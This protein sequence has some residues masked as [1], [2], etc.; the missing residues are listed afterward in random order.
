MHTHMHKHVRTNIHLHTVKNGPRISKIKPKW[1]STFDPTT[2]A[3]VHVWVSEWVGEWVSEWV[4]KWLY[5]C[6]RENNRVAFKPSRQILTGSA[7]TCCWSCSSMLG[8]QPR[9]CSVERTHT[10]TR[11]TPIYTRQQKT[12]QHTRTNTQTHARTHTHAHTHDSKRPH[13]PRPSALANRLLS[14]A[15]IIWLRDANGATSFSRH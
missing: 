4:S 12:Y 9:S 8:H 3:W 5:E 1:I 7:T 15:T 2:V 14:C 13:W 11:R 10:S 6:E